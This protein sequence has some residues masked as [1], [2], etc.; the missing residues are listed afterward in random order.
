FLNK[1]LVKTTLDISKAKEYI[2][3]DDKGS[4]L[5]LLI[6][7]Q[8]IILNAVKYSS[9]VSK[10]SRNLHIKFKA[11]NNNISITVSNT[12]KPNV[13]VKSSGLGQE[14]I[15]NF[16]KLLQTE[17]IINTDNNLYSVEI[18]FKNIWRIDQ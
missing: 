8:E 17:P 2:I 4:A 5:K 14:I 11:D 6:I 16:S 13:Q 3:G 18:R 12:F 1:H 7:I 15:R 9:F 10:E